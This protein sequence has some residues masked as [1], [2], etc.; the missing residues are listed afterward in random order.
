MSA[1]AAP[2]RIAEDTAPDLRAVGGTVAVDL[3]ID[4]GVETLR[5]VQA[6]TAATS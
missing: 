5:I 1:G 4:N 3:T 2:E 6:Q